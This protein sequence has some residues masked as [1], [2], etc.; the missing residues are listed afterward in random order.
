M[1]ANGYLKNIKKSRKITAGFLAAAAV[2]VLLVVALNGSLFYNMISDQSELICREQ[3]NTVSNDLKLMISDSEKTLRKLELAL[4]SNM[5]DADTPDSYYSFL[6]EIKNNDDYSNCINIYAAGDDWF[7]APDFDSSDFQANDRVW[8]LGARKKGAGNI[9]VS[10]PYIDIITGRMCFTLS[11]LLDNDIVIGIDYDLKELQNSLSKAVKSGGEALIANAEGQIICY[12]DENV[13]GKKISESLPQYT[14]ILRKIKSSGEDDKM[15]S[16]DIDDTRSEVFYSKTANGW[17]L[18]SSVSHWILYKESYMRLIYNSIL[19]LIIVLIIIALFFFNKRNQNKI[20]RELEEKEN[21]YSENLSKLDGPINL[22]LQSSSKIKNEMNEDGNK[23]W[24]LVNELKGSVALIKDFSFSERKKRFEE[25]ENKRKKRK[26]SGNESVTIR[27]QNKIVMIAVI[28]AISIAMGVSLISSVYGLVNGGNS[29]MEGLTKNYLSDVQMWETEQKGAVETFVKGLVSN[30]DIMNDYEGV[31]EWLNNIAEQYDDISVAYI[32]NPDRKDYTFAESGHYEHNDDIDW[33]VEERPWYL[34]VVNSDN[35]DEICISE[36][37]IDSKTGMYC[38]SF[39]KAMY[40]KTGKFLG[41][42][43]ADFY[44]DKL[45]KILSD[46]YS[47]DGYAFIADHEGRIINHPNKAYEISSESQM[48][49]E[50]AGYLNAVYSDSTIT[51][52][53]YDG[54]KK[55]IYSLIEPYSNFNVICVKNWSVIYGR[56]IATSLSLAFIFAVSLAVTI[57]ILYKQMKWQKEANEILQEAVD[58][59]EYAGKAK[60]Q[61]L[62]QMSH[63]IRTPIN[64]VLGM[65]EMILRECDNGNILGYA[66]NIRNAGRT[67]LSLINSILDFSKLEDDKMEI[68]PV[69]YDTASLINDLVNMVQERAK[70]K[71]LKFTL[72][73]DP[74]LP[75]TMYGDDVRVRQVITNILTNAVKYTEEGEVWL[76]ISVVGRDSNNITI[77]IEVEDT[78]IGIKPENIEGLFQSFKRLDLEKNRNIE[79]TGLGMSIVQK[80]LRLMNSK[81]GV[82]SVYGKGSKFYFDIVQGV[83][84]AE[85]IGD[86][87]K[88]LDEKQNSKNAEEYVYAPNARVLI[89]DDNNMNLLVAKGLLKRTGM[90]I[91]TALSGKDAIELIKENFYD[92]VFLDHMMPQLDGIQTLK[93]MKEQ[94]LIPDNTSV[95]MMTANAIV[96]AREEY[97][98]EGF[99]NYIS[100]PI[101]VKNMDELLEE[102]IPAEKLSYKTES[103]T[104]KAIHP[105]EKIVKKEEAEPAKFTKYDKL[106]LIHELDTES[107]IRY[108][109]NNE[110]FYIELVKAYASDDPSEQLQFL[111]DKQEYEKYKLLAHKTNVCSHNIGADSAAK[112]AAA[113]ESAAD[114]K[115]VELVRQ[116]HK[117]L[118]KILSRLISSIK[119]ALDMR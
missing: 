5:N 58:A 94:E 21:F 1:K 24:E 110:K 117:S 15:F 23:L 79:G 60:S 43:G 37:Y 82:E 55:A 27:K 92:I 106:R 2:L 10:S 12:N 76:R 95:I 80:L 7:V 31:I 54:A 48:T 9:F 61:F 33:K 44:F 40:D 36:P 18:I 77:H 19:N 114:D 70:K 87:K 8:Y 32:G 66:E 69:N 45:I 13:I 86:Y 74:E 59:A 50:E 16:A 115:D 78:G 83:V 72:E 17:Y 6:E 113:A 52:T 97:L 38:I 65:N 96:G 85:G 99:D 84:D 100:K 47:D 22:M 75:K 28:I 63:E 98:K 107:G 20:D 42:F 46:S 26:N 11:M 35:K 4:K 93:I 89:V 103:G 51:I 30:P 39:S 71:G 25:K 34:N 53:D 49:L 64:A 67:L 118:L 102:Y 3:L 119:N 108:C 73:C 68:V 41:V 62:A 88:R 104:V 57:Y 101:D 14:N 91:D 112:A 81:L 105:E 116:K 109:L 56:V 29:T 111:L 90:Y